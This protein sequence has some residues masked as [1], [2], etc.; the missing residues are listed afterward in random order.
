MRDEGSYL[1]P[2]QDDLEAIR[3]Q[4]I[5]HCELCDDEGY[6][7]ARVCDH[8]DHVAQS[9]HGRALAQAALA[10]IAA[11]IAHKPADQTGGGQ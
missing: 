6:R 1:P 4:A 3:A 5:A 8:I 11:R 10:E 7:C 2:T 9:A